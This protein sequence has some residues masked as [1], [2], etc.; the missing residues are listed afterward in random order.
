VVTAERAG[1]DGRLAAATALLE[2]NPDLAAD[3]SDA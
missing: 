3:S 2:D 1:I